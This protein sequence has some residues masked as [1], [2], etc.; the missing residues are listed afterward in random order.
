MMSLDVQLVGESVAAWSRICSLH[1]MPRLEGM[2]DIVASTLAR[3][4]FR[5]RTSLLHLAAH[6]KHDRYGHLKQIR[7]FTNARILRRPVLL[8]RDMFVIGERV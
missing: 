4:A 3:Q 7:P 6:R 5:S 2:N 1:A 8:Q